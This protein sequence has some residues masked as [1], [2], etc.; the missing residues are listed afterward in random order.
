[1]IS[2]D[3]NFEA[4]IR[5]LE[6]IANSL[7]DENTTIDK[8]VELFEKGIKLSKDCS[9]YLENVKQKITLLTDLEGEDVND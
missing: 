1:M 8:S 2:N 5:Q 6:N 7:E 9:K 4:A 3:F